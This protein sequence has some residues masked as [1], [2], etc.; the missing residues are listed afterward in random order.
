MRWAMCWAGTAILF[1]LFGVAQGQE[2]GFLSRGKAAAIVEAIVNR[3]QSVKRLDMLSVGRKIDLAPNGRIVLG[4]LGSC[5]H[6]EIWG[7]QVTVE[8]QLSRVEGGRVVRRRVECD[9][10]GLTELTTGHKL[11]PRGLAKIAP[12]ALPV[13]TIVLFGR[14]P[15][16]LLTER[17]ETLVLDRLDTGAPQ[18]RVAASAANI[19]LADHGIALAPNG[20]YRASAGGAKTVFQIDGLAES[21]PSPVVGRLLPLR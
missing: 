14:S 4:Y 20:L 7:G 17:A 12:A 8:E 18:I 15:I 2:A 19:D 5:W 3:N 11:T 10:V 1:A 9:P 21:G 16:V 13:P 6:E